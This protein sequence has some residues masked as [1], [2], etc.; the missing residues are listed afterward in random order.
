[1]LLYLYT[2]YTSIKANLIA[3]IKR[4]SFR[5]KILHGN[6]HNVTVI[7]SGRESRADV[8]KKYAIV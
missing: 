5:R 7:L 6:V 4:E 3:P 8:R 2:V 1:M